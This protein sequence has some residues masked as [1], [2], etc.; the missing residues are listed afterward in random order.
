MIFPAAWERGRFTTWKI[1]KEEES[2]Q[3]FNLIGPL[4]SEILIL[5]CKFQNVP[6]FEIK[7]SK[8]FCR[9]FMTYRAYNNFEY[10]FHDK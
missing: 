10:G 1:N 8:N 3:N 2:I 5:I 6:G 7:H 4:L 9:S